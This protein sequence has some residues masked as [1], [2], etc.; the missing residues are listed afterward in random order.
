MSIISY[1]HSVSTNF[2]RSYNDFEP[3]HATLSELHALPYP[4][5]AFGDDRF[6]EEA[7]TFSAYGLS[8]D[9]MFLPGRMSYLAL[10]RPRKAMHGKKPAKDWPDAN[11]KVAITALSQRISASP[12]P[13]SLP[14]P[15]IPRVSK[16]STVSSP[17]KR[18][19]F[20]DSTNSIFSSN[21]NTPRTSMVSVS[22]KENIAPVPC[23]LRTSPTINLSKS[24]PSGYRTRIS[25]GVNVA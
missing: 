23:R 1:Q 18:L 4:A 24:K 13:A 19:I 16:V 21:A 6:E 11:D 15:V 17:A 9:D 8:N 25:R 7:Y 2:D 14:K 20:S 12:T 3:H 10:R 22:N 5:S